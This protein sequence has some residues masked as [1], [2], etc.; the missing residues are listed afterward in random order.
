MSFPLSII[1][2]KSTSY[3][4]QLLEYNFH[5]TDNSMFNVGIK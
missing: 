4:F 3:A 5:Q 2:F 1:V